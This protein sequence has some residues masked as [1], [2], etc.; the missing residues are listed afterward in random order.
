V[1]Q[2]KRVE[3]RPWTRADLEPLLE[4]AGFLVAAHGDMQG[5]DFREQESTDLVLVATKRPA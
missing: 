3:L 1:E 4:S 2:T 5:G